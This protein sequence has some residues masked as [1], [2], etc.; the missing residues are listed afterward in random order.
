MWNQTNITS[1]TPDSRWAQLMTNGSPRLRVQRASGGIMSSSLKK[2]V[3]IPFPELRTIIG[4]LF[5][6]RH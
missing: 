1:N 3:S 5:P 4:C 6:S 2:P